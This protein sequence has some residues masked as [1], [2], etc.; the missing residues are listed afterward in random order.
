MS[1]GERDT[2]AYEHWRTARIAELCGPTP[3]YVKP[4]A[5]DAWRMDQYYKIACLDLALIGL[6]PIDGSG[7]QPIS[8]DL[9]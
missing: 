5:A 2:A 9:R 1:Q 8:R 6:P 7:Y 3:E 4:E